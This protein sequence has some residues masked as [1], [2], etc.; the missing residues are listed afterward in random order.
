MNGPDSTT[1][2]TTAITTC[3]RQPPHTCTVDGPCNGWPK[4]TTTNEFDLLYALLHIDPTAPIR[5]DVDLKEPNV[6]L[7][8]GGWIHY[9]IVYNVS[10]A[11]ATAYEIAA[12]ARTTDE[13]P[14]SQ[15]CQ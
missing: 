5:I 14:A 7:M 3:T 4:T 6:D 13:T 10:T 11:T 1:D 9:N 12:L 8:I 2:I 15:S